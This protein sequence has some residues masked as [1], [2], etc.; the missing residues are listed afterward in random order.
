MSVRVAFKVSLWAPCRNPVQS[1]VSFRVS[2]TSF[3]TF[4][5]VVNF[6]CFLT[7]WDFLGV[8]VFSHTPKSKLD[9]MLLDPELLNPKPQTPKP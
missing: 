8:W 7:F 9:Q 3:E 1:G 2:G 5:K 4:G 6:L